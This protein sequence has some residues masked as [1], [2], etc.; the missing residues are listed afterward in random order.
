MGEDLGGICYL[1]DG[2]ET[3]DEKWI[4]VVALAVICA[5]V[6]LASHRHLVRHDMKWITYQQ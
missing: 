1:A 6:V 2:G 3:K 4:S 5:L